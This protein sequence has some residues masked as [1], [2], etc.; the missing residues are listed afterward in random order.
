MA[1]RPWTHALRARLWPR[2][3]GTGSGRAA[4]SGRI[5]RGLLIS[6]AALGLAIVV[7]LIGGRPLGIAVAV[8]VG[9]V[10]LRH[11]EGAG[12]VFAGILILNLP[13]IGV[14][15]YGVPPA[16][17]GAASLLLLV[18]VGVA[19]L[20][21]Q[22]I[23]VRTPALPWL[24]AYLLA[25]LLAA[26]GS[27][28]LN[29][30][31]TTIG[32]FLLEGLLLYLLVTSGLRTREDIHR[33]IWVLVLAGGLLGAVSIHQEMNHAYEDN[34]LGLA[35]TQTGAIR[36]GSAAGEVEERPRLAGPIGETNR[37][38]QVMLVL[39]PLPFLL[40]RTESRRSLRILALA[41]GLAILA[42]IALTF[43]RGA[44]L[45]LFFLLP[46]MCAM[47]YLR[48]RALLVGGAAFVLV[49]V[50]AVPGFGERVASVRGVEGLFGD[51]AADTSPDGAILGRAT[52]NLAALNT[53]LDHPLTGVGPGV[54]YRDYSKIYANRLGLRHFEEDRRAH[55][56]Y[57]ETAADSGLIGLAAL[58][59][60]AGSTLVALRR[61][62][63]RA[64]DRGDRWGTDVTAALL[65]S[66]IAYL[67]TA[68]FLHLSYERYFWFLIALANVVA[69]TV[70]ETLWR[71]PATW[72]AASRSDASSDDVAQLRH[73]GTG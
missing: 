33:V 65:F 38:A 32:G 55:N 41:C 49:A 21:R 66:V 64:R 39:L 34:Y 54:Y 15:F 35:Q 52:S 16:L 46:L 3:T 71:L 25:M 56:M 5:S 59:G 20:K 7:A 13:A 63:R 8:L 57:L 4:W 2:R 24:L 62:G 45:V 60:V 50:V 68:V 61:A 14:R 51:A 28:N 23:L 17:A 40:I 37:Y 36:V 43:S 10:L 27:I 42:A 58:L 48:W 19:V 9:V 70:G 31:A 22:P 67:G 12:L 11:P 18:P 1:R 73:A 69:I 26:V 6:G 53:F 44:I 29:A 30:A 72:R 47:G